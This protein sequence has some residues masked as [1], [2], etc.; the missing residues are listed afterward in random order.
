MATHT[1][2]EWRIEAGQVLTVEPECGNCEGWDFQNIDIHAGDVLVAVVSMS[3]S[4]RPG[5]PRMTDSAEAAA[6]ARLVAAAP[7]MLAALR[8]VLPYAGGML[9]ADIK[10]SIF[11]ATGERS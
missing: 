8:G 7:Q 9:A 10:E 6:N 5:V 1:G 4:P 3:Q 11:A 2:G